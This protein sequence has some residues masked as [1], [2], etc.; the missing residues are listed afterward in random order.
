MRDFGPILVLSVFLACGIV[1][2]WRQILTVCIIGCLAIMFVGLL[3]VM[4]ETKGRSAQ[5]SINQR[6]HTASQSCY[7]VGRSPPR[8]EHPARGARKRRAPLR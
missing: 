5:A 1:A 8:T 3:G 6:P 7:W 4:S 2:M